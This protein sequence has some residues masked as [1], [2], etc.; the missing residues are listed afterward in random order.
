MKPKR[1][2]M[3]ILLLASSLLITGVAAAHSSGT[4]L[5]WFTIDS[6]G[7]VLTSAEPTSGY[8]MSGTTGQ[9]DAARLSAGGYQLSGGFW[10]GFEPAR[11]LIYLPS[12]RR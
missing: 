1:F 7:G 5:D 8:Q 11:Q 12:V 2:W 10:T 3:V 6:G 4:V 9:P